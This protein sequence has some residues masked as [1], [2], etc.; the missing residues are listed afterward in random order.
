MLHALIIIEMYALIKKKKKVVWFAQLLIV[1]NLNSFEFFTS[2]FILHYPIQM[3]MMFS[4]MF[5]IQI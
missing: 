2:V 5:S 3:E 1:I 4:Q